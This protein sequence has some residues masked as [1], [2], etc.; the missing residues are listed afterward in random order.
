MGGVGGR[1]IDTELE[2][3]VPRLPENGRATGSVWSERARR[4][5]FRWDPVPGAGYELEVDDSCVA[6]AFDDCDFP[7]PEWVERDLVMPESSPPV[8]LPVSEV[9]PVGRRYFWRVRSCPGAAC[10][11]WSAVRYVDVG[12]QKSD[13]DGDGYADVVLTAP[14][15]SAPLH[16][17][18]LVGFGPLPSAR[19]VVLE[20]AP[21]PEIQDL[22]GDVAEPLGDLDADGFADLLVT[23]P[24]DL[25][26]GGH[27]DV[28]FGNPTFGEI[29]PSFLS[30][31][32]DSDFS[33]GGAVVSAG[34]VDADGHQ[35]FV[36]GS[37][38]WLLRGASDDVIATELPL[39]LANDEYVTDLSAGDVT[40][41][42]YSDLFAASVAVG[43][44]GP[45]RFDF[46][47]GGPGGFDDAWTL[48]ESDGPSTV[49]NDRNGDGFRDLGFAFNV[50]NDPIPNRIDVAHGA[51][52]PVAD[53]VA[54][55]G[56]NL[57]AGTDT[58][59]YG[60]FARPIAAGDINGDG[61][62]DTLVGVSWHTS[63]LVQANLYVG[64]AGSPTAPDAVYTI[65][66]EFLL[67]VSTGF[68]R[69]IGDVNGD[70]FDDVFLNDDFGHKGALF[71]GGSEFDTAPDD[72]L[73]L[74]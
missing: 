46:L 44:S 18:V 59:T 17:Q 68:P 56:A 74:P 8:G 54:T 19:W 41:D 62:D 9:A 20:E 26:P 47:R 3:P 11:P 39:V 28:Y 27:A 5:R 50:P 35:D 66:S 38:P 37:P 36:A 45:T 12:R 7:S 10:S 73:T 21:V 43:V 40:G 60:E 69:A 22:F 42:G 6:N 64:G 32:G 63:N 67:F 25:P 48:L 53:V 2:V 57:I 33:F 52:P 1:P 13:F 23:V 61:Y 30:P 72:E 51:D 55:L 49:M 14:G 34:D 15:N 4:P 16:G 31:Q 24:G 70:G 29:S 71:F 65:R 58:G